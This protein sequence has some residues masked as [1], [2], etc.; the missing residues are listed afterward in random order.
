MNKHRNWHSGVFF[1]L[2]YDLHA[3]AEDTNLGEELTVEHLVERLERVR[4]DW[5][6]CDCKGH[7]GYTSWPTEVG[8]TSPGMIVDQLA[9][10]RE[11]TRRLGIPLGMHYSGVYD[12]RAVELHPEWARR[13]ADGSADARFTCRHSAY[14]DELMI[15]QMLELIDRYD[16]D[17]F[18]VDG[19][20][21]ASYPCWCDACR[22]GFTAATGIAEA[23][24]EKGQPHWRDWCDYHRR[25]FIDYVTHYA[26][27]V[28]ARKPACL[29][30]SNW[31]YTIRQPEPIEAPV[32]YLSGD[33]TPQWGADRAAL[34]GRMLD[35]RQ[36]TWDLMAWGFIHQP[37][38]A[39]SE[40]KPALHL[41]QEV[42]EVVALGG[43]VMVYAKPQ[44]SGWLVGWHHDMLAEV[45][46]FCRER[47]SLC[48]QT[49][50]GSEAA[51]LHLADHY[52][53]VND[54]L[55]NYGSAIQPVEGALQVLLECGLSTDILT[56]EVAL[57]RPEQYRLLVVP[58]QTRLSPRLQEHLERFA[59]GGGTV[60]LTGSHLARECPK[61]VGVEAVD[62][63]ITPKPGAWG[64][65]FLEV[66]GRAEPLRGDWQAVKARRGTQ[67]WSRVLLDEEPGKDTSEHPAVTVRPVGAGR[68]VHL[69]GPLFGNYAA[70]HYPDLRRFVDHLLDQLTIPWQVVCEAPPWC[71]LIVRRQGDRLLLNLLNRG[72]A[73]TLS[74]R[75]TIV[76]HLP[77]VRDVRLKVVREKQPEAIHMVPDDATLD[78]NWS[79]GRVNLYLDQVPLHQVIVIE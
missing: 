8:S 19:E 56:E 17:G 27:A 59:S 22:A 32:D 75:R 7:P 53:A 57:A 74:P 48:W 47:Q 49:A 45:A 3:N 66:A 35:S 73:E 64:S 68:I 69:P 16:V 26:D 21:W 31:M 15:P 14:V 23:P 70:A 44:R 61:L 20:N 29:I 77:P 60:L 65:G 6:Q 28:H 10:Y 67:V 51:V 24:T 42:A 63:P 18:W 40:T 33:F 54:P 52:Y 79:H 30:C 78:W 9:I 55:Y 46:D 62:A 50:S 11:A 2:H 4:P 43:S 58:E 13:A 71:E 5:I 34:E 39:P 38:Q 76:E 72:A 1:G 36:L 12:E 37:N 25:L 41:Q